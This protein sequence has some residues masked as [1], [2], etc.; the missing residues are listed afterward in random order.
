MKLLFQPGLYLLLKKYLGL[1]QAK[2][3][4]VK[5]KQLVLDLSC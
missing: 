2:T 4:I 1:R 3:D 5:N